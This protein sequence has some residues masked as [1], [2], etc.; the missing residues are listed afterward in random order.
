[1]SAAAAGQAAGGSAPVSGIAGQ[2]P[3][4]GA[5]L[6]PAPRPGI[7]QQ[8]GGT[9]IV[10]P[11]FQPHEMLYPHEYKA[12]YPPYYYKVNGGWFVSPFGVWSQ[13]NWKL[14]GTTVKVKYH[15]HI[16]PFAL[17]KPPVS[18]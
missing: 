8:V 12:M 18:R 1:M 17:F 4:T 14:Q 6:Y 11:A 3:Q 2:Y 5:P 10:H 9:A 15:S 16:S 13:E 7:P